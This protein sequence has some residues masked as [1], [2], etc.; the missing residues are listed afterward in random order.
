MRRWSLNRQRTNQSNRIQ[1]PCAPIIPCAGGFMRTRLRLVIV[2]LLAIWAVSA[3]D[4]QIT[5]NPIPAPIAKRGLAVEIK[6]LV[7]LP[8]TRGIR[9]A[10]QD[11]SPAGWARVSYVRDLPDG[12]RFA[13]DSRG[14]LYLIDSNNQPQVYANV[15][16]VFPNAV[17]NRL[18]SGFI[19]VRLSSGVRAKRLV[20]HGACR[21]RS[22]QSQ[23]A[24]LHPARVHREGRD[25]PQHHH[26]VACDEPGGERFRRNETRT[27]CARLTLSQTSRIRWARLSSTRRRSPAIRTTDCFTPAAAIT[28]SATAADR[29][30][31]PPARRS[32]STRS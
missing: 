28:D 3:I 18:E 19:G 26:G 1:L 14:F 16:A 21:A 10:D 20:L 4:A 29:T 31:T 12:R 9:P 15:A 23:D 5:S 2:L 7:R 17:Y 13:N 25:L 30:R 22:G 24:R 32:A 27:L 6:D 8:D 11:V